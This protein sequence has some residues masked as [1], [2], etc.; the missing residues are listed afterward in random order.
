MTELHRNLVAGEWVEGEDATDDINPS[1]TD[2]VVG[3]YAR[4]SK[5]D[6]ER[7]IA[8]AKA[9]LPRLVALRHPA[10]LRD[11][12]E[13]L[14]RDPGAQGRARAASVPRGGKDACRGDRRDRARRPDLC[15]LRGRG[16][17][18]CGRDRAERQ[19]R[20]GGDDRARAGRRR[21]ADHAVEFSDRHPRLEA[22]AG[23]RL[24]QHGGDEAGRP[25]AGLHLGARRYPRPR[26][27]AERRL[28]P[29]HGEG[30]GCRSGDPR[31]PRRER[32]LLHRLDRDGKA[33]RESVGGALAPLPA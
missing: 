5:A 26:G 12:E 16:A 22:R 29:R 27:P 19:A 10:A 9:A 17:A 25:C 24:R 6:A 31:Q 11:P 8:A 28:E 2:E 4:G 18:A 15:V 7:A 32:H 13:G 23:A 30:L 20:R 33:C 3:T 1:N 21:R 14:R